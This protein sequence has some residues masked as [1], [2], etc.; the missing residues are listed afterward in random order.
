MITVHF[1]D[2][3]FRRVKTSAP[4]LKGGQPGSLDPRF[5]LLPGKM[6]KVREAGKGW[7][8][9]GRQAE[10]WVSPPH[11]VAEAGGRIGGGCHAGGLPAVTLK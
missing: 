5:R 4:D 2:E 3:R 11:S 9:G 6:L 10:G 8:A 7:E 1:T